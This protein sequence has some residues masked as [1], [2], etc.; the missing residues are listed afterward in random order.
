MP[1]LWVGSVDLEMEGI[2]VGT[3]RECVRR[4][5]RPGLNDSWC[6]EDGRNLI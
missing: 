3:G 4:C 2:F 6:R 5:R 1:K